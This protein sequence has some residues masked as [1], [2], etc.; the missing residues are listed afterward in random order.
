MEAIL[1]VLAAILADNLLLSRLFGIE[2]FFTA[3]EKPS[4]A[5]LYGGL[6]T[7][8]TVVAGSA[9][10]ALYK[11]VLAPLKITHFV[12]FLSVAVITCVICAIQLISSKVLGKAGNA[13]ESALP[14]VSSNCVVIGSILLCIENGFSF[15]ISVLFLLA[16]GV[17]FTLVMLVFS[18]VQMRLE[19]SDMADSF[20]GI[21]ILLISCAL[22]AMAFSGFYG[23]SF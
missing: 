5:A 18:S 11:F 10:L 7:C 2:S 4:G 20:R 19:N 1:V 15:P 14:V 12:T 16:A 22:A 8:V 13:V 23:L 17:G 9:V 6:V 3:T 21:P